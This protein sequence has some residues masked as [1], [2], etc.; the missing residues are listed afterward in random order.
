MT[1]KRDDKRE[2]ILKAATQCFSRFGYDKTTLQ[3]IGDAARLNKASLY[4]Y[5]K[6]KEDLFI[7]VVLREAER[8]LTALQE[9]VQ[10]LTRATDK[11]LAYLLGRLDYYR[12]VLNL[13]Q[14]S[15]ESLQRLEP[16]FDDVYQA[17]REQELTFLG[18][19]LREGVADREFLKLQ[20]ERAA[21]ALLAVADG[22]KHEAVQRSRTRFAYEVDYAPVQE[23]MTYTLTLLL[24][25]LKK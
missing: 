11:I 13:H 18:Q 22:I 14:L 6:N 3:D 17:V 8:Y 21:D 19:L 5:Y 9:Q 10:P 23:K 1:V 15:I 2:A 4:Y 16:M 25:G 12:Q 20:P 7:Q 24:A